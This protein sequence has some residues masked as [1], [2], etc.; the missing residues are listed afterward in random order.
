VVEF[1]L[2]RLE[3]RGEAV[4][5]G[6]TLQVDVSSAINYAVSRSGVLAYVPARER[7]R[8]FVWVDRT[9]GRETAIDALLPSQYESVG[10]SPDDGRVAFALTDRDSE[11]FTYDFAQQSLNRLTFDRSFD[12]LPRWTPDGQRIVFMSDRD[13]PLNLYSVAS[14][15]SGQVE[16]LTTSTS[17]QYTNS[18]TRDG[19][20]LFAEQRP[21]TG[22][23]IFRLPLAAPQGAARTTPADDRLPE[24]TELVS[25]SSHEYAANISPN[26]RYFAYQSAES[27][28]RFAVYVQP[29]PDASRRWRISTGGG[30]APVWARTERELF[31]LDE[32]N[33]LMAVPVDTSGPQ[34]TV[35]RP[36]K[37][38]DTK[39]W[40]NFYSYDVTRGGRFLM[41]KDVG[42]SQA[43]IVVVLNWFEELRRRTPTR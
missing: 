25:T 40:G 35:G 22:Y 8:S 14:D 31:Y 13:G 15:G 42:Q 11:I 16:R 36:A 2:D 3:V 10:L 18:I 28:G 19:T 33:T 26:G 39:Y 7:L 24:A 9:T 12:Y 37:V 23:D 1:D 5:V 29:Y 20:I 43:S 21:N 17:D 6:E 30:T 27:D 4:R 34:L 38:F 41:L 32:A